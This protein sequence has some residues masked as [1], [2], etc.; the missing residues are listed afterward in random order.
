MRIVHVQHPFVSGRGYQENHLP[1]EQAALGHDVE[2]V[3][4]DFHPPKFSNTEPPC[5]GS[6]EE[7]GVTITRLPSMSAMNH[8]DAVKIG[9]HSKLQTI[10]PDIIHAHG[11]FR[12]STLRSMGY[13]FNRDCALVVDSHVDNDNFHI[14]SALKKFGWVTFRQI[15]FPI[16]DWFVDGYLPVNPVAENLLLEDFSVKPEK[17]QMLPLGVDVGQFYPH[18]Q[19][20]RELRAKLGVDDKLVFVTGGN[21]DKTKDLDVLLEAFSRL[22]NQFEDSHLL[23]VG[24]GES[25]FMNEIKNLV[26]KLNISRRVSFPGFQNHDSLRAYYNAADVGVWP[27]KLGITIIE[28]MACGLPLIVSDNPATARLVRNDNGFLVERKDTEDL[29]KQMRQYLRTPS[30]ID[31]HGKNSRNYALQEYSWENI[32]K[33]SIRLYRAAIEEGTLD[34]R[35]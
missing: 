4:S 15:L 18:E 21:L 35:K 25:E 8:A 31:E 24:S 13:V 20:R 26:E 11:L 27:G 30:C 33:K 29:Y 16:M 19:E 34:W 22:P 32:A 23:I 9:L 1:F 12:S 3:T 28:A 7:M 6:M 17:I 14:D 2:L 5:P 10:N